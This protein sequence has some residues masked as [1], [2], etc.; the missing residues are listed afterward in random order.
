MLRTTESVDPKRA[1]R[2]GRTLAISL[3]LAACVGGLSALSAQEASPAPA[4]AAVS[5]PKITVHGF[6]SQAYAKSDGHQILGISDQGSADYRSAALQIRAD[7]SPSDVFV[8]Q[9]SH[10]RLGRSPVMSIKSDVELD[11]IFYE[12]RFGDSAVKVGRVQIPFGIYNEVLDVGTILPFYRPSRNFYGETAYSSETVDGVVLTHTFNFARGWSLDGDVYFGNLQF[13]ERN[14]ETGS[15]VKSN[16]RNTRGAEVWI[17]TP[18]AGVRLGGGAVAYEIDSLFAK[19]TWKTKHL[20]LSAERKWFDVHSEIKWV[21]LGVGKLE[22]GYVQAGV[23]FTDKLRL[24]IQQD[25]FYA[26]LTGRRERTDSDRAL[27]LNYAF[28][29]GLVLK[30]EHHWTEGSFWLEDQSALGPPTTKTR[31][32]ILSLATS[33]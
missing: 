2:R 22:L 33:F 26:N 23:H 19:G 28:N 13:P 16:A 27:G 7:I 30:A 15:Y 31:Y 20:S 21:D 12:H 3:A 1:R 24:N 29:P 5:G 14:F 6:L 8:V 11:W 17:D 32:W 18:V 10:E 4:E 9:I 25:L